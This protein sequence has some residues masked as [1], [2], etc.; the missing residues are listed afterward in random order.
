MADVNNERCEKTKVVDKA[1][2]IR[3]L[4]IVVYCMILARLLLKGKM[5][6]LSGE[7]GK[8]SS[9]DVASSVSKFE[10]LS[11][12]IQDDPFGTCRV[13]RVSFGAQTDTWVSPLMAQGGNQVEKRKREN[14]CTG[15]IEMTTSRRTEQDGD[16]VNEGKRRGH[17]FKV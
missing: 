15:K 9:R 16:D 3:G 11:C 7:G 10:R 5:I 8:S 17:W 2:T 1:V 12:A 4:G 6:S 14:G 13:Y